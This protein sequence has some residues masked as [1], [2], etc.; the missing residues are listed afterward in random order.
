MRINVRMKGLQQAQANMQKY[1]ASKVENVKKIVAKSTTNI[2][3]GA[4]SRAPVAEID[5]G[6]LK[7]GIFK[8]FANDDLVG[9]VISP[10]RHQAKSLRHDSRYESPTLFIPSLRGRETSI[11]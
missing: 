6:N 5:G 11:Y 3:N 9:R 1:A 8:E 2:E 4:V 10:A 7:N